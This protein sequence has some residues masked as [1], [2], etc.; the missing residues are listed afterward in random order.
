M[1]SLYNYNGEQIGV[2]STNL[3]SK[4]RIQAITQDDNIFSVISKFLMS[5]HSRKY[6]AQNC[7]VAQLRWQKKIQRKLDEK[8]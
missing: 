2:D 8:N 1:I 7:G 6:F 3:P 5:G 4:V